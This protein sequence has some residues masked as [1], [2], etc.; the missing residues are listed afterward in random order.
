[1]ALFT[2]SFILLRMAGGSFA[3]PDKANQIDAVRS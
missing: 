1:M 3:G 2:S